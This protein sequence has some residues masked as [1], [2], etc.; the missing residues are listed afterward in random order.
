MFDA[1]FNRFRRHIGVLRFPALRFDIAECGCRCLCAVRN[2]RKS[3]ARFIRIQVR[4]KPPRP[5]QPQN[6]D[7]CTR[8]Y[9][10]GALRRQSLA[11]RIRQ[12]F[13]RCCLCRLRLIQA[14]LSCNA[15]IGQQDH[16]FRIQGVP[17]LQ[18]GFLNALKLSQEAGALFHSLIDFAR[19]P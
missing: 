12:F 14:C 4:H 2:R 18:N 5:Q 17:R 11:I 1:P 10:L 8:T 9:L 16:R 19:Q 6:K 3:A 7:G 15:L 13:D